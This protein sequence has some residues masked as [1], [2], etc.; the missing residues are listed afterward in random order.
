[1]GEIFP[2]TTGGTGNR[3]KGPL[4]GHGV[5]VGPGVCVCVCTLLGENALGCHEQPCTHCSDAAHRNHHRPS[6]KRAEPPKE[7]VVSL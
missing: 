6:K 5:T 2:G 1:M 3:G 7:D 4:C